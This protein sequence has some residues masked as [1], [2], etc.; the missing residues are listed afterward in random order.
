[1]SKQPHE[2]TS[3][4]FNQSFPLWTE[5]S[6]RMKWRCYRLNNNTNLQE[7]GEEITWEEFVKFATSEQFRWV[8]DDMTLLID[9]RHEYFIQQALQYGWDIPSDVLAEYP[10]MVEEFI[11]KKIATKRVQQK[12]LESRLREKE[13]RAYEK[14]VSKEDR[15]FWRMFEDV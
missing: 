13:E 15:D 3:T 11:S 2:M 10:D 1:M 6:P 14:K 5:L 7:T 12:R 8:T 9:E 4:E